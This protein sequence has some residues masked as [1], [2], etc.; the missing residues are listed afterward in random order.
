MGLIGK[1][2]AYLFPSADH[3]QPMSIRSARNKFDLILKSTSIALKWGNWH[4]RGPCM[5]CFRH[6]FVFRP[7]SKAEYEGRSISDSMPFLLIYLGH[8][9]LIET[10][11]Y[12][13]F[14]SEIYPQALNLFEEY[15]REVFPEVDYEEEIH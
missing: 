11:K 4:E 10:D 14:S 8:D 2:D 13:K 15:A 9:S 7:F 3:T 1:S 12:L 5:H 6:L